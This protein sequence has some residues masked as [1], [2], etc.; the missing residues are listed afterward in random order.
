M[1]S[2]SKILF[3]NRLNEKLHIRKLNFCSVQASGS[4]EKIEMKKFFVWRNS[5]Q[6]IYL[7]FGKNK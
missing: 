2:D 4:F 6:R 3:K 1:E 7:A 5:F